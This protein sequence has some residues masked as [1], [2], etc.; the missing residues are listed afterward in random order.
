[1]RQQLSQSLVILSLFSVLAIGAPMSRAEDHAAGT[2]TD[3]HA[4]ATAKKMD[5][6]SDKASEEG[7]TEECKKCQ[8]KE[9][10]T[11]KECKKEC[12]KHCKKG[13]KCCKGKKHPGHH[14]SSEKEKT[15]ETEAD[16]PKT[17]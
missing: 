10:C 17:E 7:M 4:H 12:K 8:D 11:T 2:P 5:K 14:M 16:K 1:M 15:T 3:E 6:A 13:G 9:H